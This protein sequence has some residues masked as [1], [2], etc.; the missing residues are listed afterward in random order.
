MRLIGRP[1][2]AAETYE[3]ERLI[4]GID[5]G[6]D[7]LGKHRRGASEHRRA[8]F[9]HGDQT[10]ANECC[11]NNFFG[12]RR[13]HYD[14]AFWKKSDFCQK[15]NIYVRKMRQGPDEFI[16]CNMSAKLPSYGR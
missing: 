2:G 1:F 15:T 4:A 7:G 3:K 10:V 9:G 8:E 16:R 6:V 14:W 11:I 5:N 12:I 13:G